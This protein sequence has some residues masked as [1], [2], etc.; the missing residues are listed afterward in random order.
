[1]SNSKIIIS[2]I[3]ITLA[4]VGMFDT[5]YLAA[6]HISGDHV[7]CGIA[8]G[9]DS[10]LNSKYSEVFG[11]PLALIGFL[12]YTTA[13]IFIFIYT[14]TNSK[15]ALSFLVKITGLGLVAS[16]YFIYLQLVV[17][18]AICTYCMLS[19]II[20]LLL[21]GLSLSTYKTPG[22]AILN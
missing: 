14:V 16:I 19:A 1:M 12:Y 6:Q 2:Y 11:I 21:F 8:E 9:C 17:L 22:K 5:A 3:L 15:K 18:E 4:L 7:A 13:L 20:T 10:V